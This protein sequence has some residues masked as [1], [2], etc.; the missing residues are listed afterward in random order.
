MNI[1]ITLEYDGSRYHG[2]QK[3]N[4]VITIQETVE[5]AIEKITGEDIKIIGSGRT[6]AG[7]HAKAQVANFNTNTSIPIEKL[8]YAINS[9]LPKDIVVNSAKIVPETFHAQKSAI[10]KIYT[11]TIYN[12]P[13][14]SPL[15]RHYVYFYPKHLDVEEM[16]KASKYFIGKHD[17]ASFKSA[18]SDVKTTVRYIENLEVRANGNLITIKMKADGFLY[19]MA[20]IIAGTLL[21]VG[22]YRKK[23]EDISYII[24]SRDRRLAGKTLPP[25]G[26][27]LEKVIY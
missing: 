10:S 20:R 4:N 23:P 24:K 25:Q 14:P 15:K 26:L 11:Y 22:L 9:Q 16:K 17:F 5:K 18:G 7:V 6:D 27:C 2:W 3:Q 13:F 12:A 1:K 19:N 8:P 21:D